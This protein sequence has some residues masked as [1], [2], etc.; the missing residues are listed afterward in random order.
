MSRQLCN[1]WQ[2]SQMFFP[3]FGH[4]FAEYYNLSMISAS[5]V[6]LLS[7]AFVFLK[8]LRHPLH[9]FIVYFGQ[10]EDPLR[11]K[12]RPTRG[13]S[14]STGSSSIISDAEWESFCDIYHPGG[15]PEGER[16][17]YEL[18]LSHHIKFC[19]ELKKRNRG[20][21]RAA[22]ELDSGTL[23]SGHGLHSHGLGLGDE[24]MNKRSLLHGQ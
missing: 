24:P 23:L 8:K 2:L 4:N 11:T 12:G 5:L 13:S 17:L 21:R 20:A 18:H 22:E 19:K 3:F 10:G 16:Q 14:V 1:S 7:P 15:A 6:H 9:I